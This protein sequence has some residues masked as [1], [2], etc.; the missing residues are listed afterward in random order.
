MDDQQFRQLLNRLGLSWEGYRK[1]RKGVKKRISR[2]MKQLGCRTVEEYFMAVGGSPEL[3]KACELLITVSISRFFRDHRLWEILESQVLP[4]IIEEKRG[5]IKVWSAGCGCG[6]E[7][8]S[9]K[10]IRDRLQRSFEGMPGLTILATDMN[11]VYLDKAQAG[12]YSWSSL[13]EI[14]EEFRSTYFEAQSKGRFYKVS[15]HL[16]KGI[17]WKIHNILSDP[18][19]TD[20]HLV[21]LRN[22]LLTYY[23]DDLKV[24]AF[25]RVVNCLAPGGFLVIGA[26]EK[27]PPVTSDLFLSF[28]HPQ[29]FQRRRHTE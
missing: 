7:V 19:G 17:V 22:N 5:D 27:L 29:I 23:Q 4:A 13:K 16:K 25:L 1:V 2:H 3:R 15:P 20:F 14:P 28:R 8:Y 21:F 10:I 26:H 24:P 6:E 11:P 12:I 9:L 18:P